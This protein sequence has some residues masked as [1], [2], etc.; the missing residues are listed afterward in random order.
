MRRKLLMTTVAASAMVGSAYAA[1]L[2][3]RAPPPAYVPPIPIFTWTGF[4]IG[5]NV[6]GA[7]RANNTGLLDNAVFFGGAAPL[8]AFVVANNNNN[9]GRFL[10]GGQAGVNWQI[11]NFVLGIEGDGDVAIGGN[12][13]FPGFLNPRTNTGFF[14]TVRG[15]GGVAFDR[16]LVYG[17]GG[18]AFGTRRDFGNTFIG[19]SFGVPTLFTTNTGS[20]TAIGYTVGAGVEYAFLNNW[21]IKGEY[22][23][24]DLGANRRTF[25]APTGA[26]VIIDA[27]REQFH[28]VWVG[29]NYRFNWGGY[30]AAAPVV[31]R[32]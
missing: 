8:A 6:G 13:N 16:L 21:S 4:Y 23:F 25:I 29:L 15:R 14:G 12:N 24:A 27:R 11:N 32:Y 30:G 5:A 22:L 28:I 20:N 26:G 9:S 10:V 19:T 17:T 3:R 7:F 18:V 31:A 1:D 2:P